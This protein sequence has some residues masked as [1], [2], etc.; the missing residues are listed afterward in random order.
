MN[1]EDLIFTIWN[2]ILALALLPSIFSENKPSAAT[3]LVTGVVLASF[4]F[5][6][7][8]I[9]FY[10]ANWVTAGAAGLWFIL[11]AQAL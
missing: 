6:F 10:W 3:S 1:R 7:N 5:S 11:F 2:F 9:N 4:S 8:R